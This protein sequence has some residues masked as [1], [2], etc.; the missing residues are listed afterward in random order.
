MDTPVFN[1]AT[2]NVSQV[3]YDD[4]PA[5][6]LA[7]ATALSCIVHPAPP[8]APSV[9]MHISWTEMR[10]GDGYWRMMSD[11]NPAIADT[12]DRDAFR[13]ALQ[14]AA[15]ERFEHAAQQGDRYF[16]IDVLGR[17][18]GVAHFYLEGYTTGTFESD[19]HFARRIGETT[20]DTYLNLLGRSIDAHPDPSDEDRARQLAY[21]TVYLFQV[22]TL[23]RGTTSGLLVHDQNDVGILGSLP[24][25]VDRDLLASWVDKLPSPQDRLLQGII[26]ALPAARPS[27]VG[28]ETKRKLAAV[29]RNHYRA[30]PDALD[31]QA[32]GDVVPPTVANHGANERR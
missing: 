20:I 1:R 28:E 15:P 13:R 31:L 5:K 8:H 12:A 29:I 3:H 32:R 6:R 18:R 30:H 7:S 24:A 27:P 11:L 9:H 21:H 2:V 4:L 17:T 25:R 22:L 19:A 16:T 10:S 26:E 23:D 14:Q